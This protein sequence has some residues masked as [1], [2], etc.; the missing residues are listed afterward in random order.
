MDVIKFDNPNDLMKME[1]GRIVNGLTS[2]TW[3]ERYSTPGE[4]TFLA[5]AASGIRD[6]LTEGS[7]VSHIDSDEIM[8]VENQ[9]I[10]E[11][12]TTVPQVKITGRSW[13][14]Y[15]EQR[16]VGNNVVFPVIGPLTDYALSAESTWRQVVAIIQDHIGPT[17]VVDPNY[18]IPFVT[19][20]ALVTPTGLEMPPLARTNKRED[21]Y[22]A[23]SDLM[24]I[25]NIGIRSIRPGA[26]TPAGVPADNMALLVHAGIDRT[27]TVGFT[28]I[29]GQVLSGTYLWSIKSL[30][31]CAL[32][33][34]TWVETTYDVNAPDGYNRRVLYVDASDLD[35]AL[36]EAPTDDDLTTLI[37]N[38]RQRGAE[39]IAAQTTTVL[40]QVNIG[41]GPKYRK[42]YGIG[43]LVSVS[44]DYN[45][46]T[47]MRV[48][49]YVETEDENGIN[50][51]P[52]LTV[53]GTT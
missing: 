53:D 23:I 20:L 44:G 32:I 37:N 36:T 15:L 39:A 4:F 9:E 33:A 12:D 38:M 41:S 22:T 13:E 1:S 6:I 35:S 48:S 47:T 27:K 43:D 16:V 28:Y 2:K 30:K 46:I 7:F 24:K 5:P 14:S 49:E 50:S 25:D 18:G 52:T 26:N 3:I 11:T 21:L 29:S 42:D 8:I 51:Y 17:D 34:S 19:V 10:D 40:S 45:E 31:N